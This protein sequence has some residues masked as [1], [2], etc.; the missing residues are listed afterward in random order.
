[1]QLPQIRFKDTD[2]LWDTFHDPGL[3]PWSILRMSIDLLKIM[4]WKQM[5]FLCQE[6]T[7]DEY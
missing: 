2:I 3:F 5:Y 7:I 1:M 4:Q 6:N